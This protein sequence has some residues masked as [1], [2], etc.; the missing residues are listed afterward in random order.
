MDQVGDQYVFGAEVSETDPNPSVWDCAE[1]TQWS[2]Y[3]VGAEIPGSSFEQYLDL[4][5]KGLVIPVEQGM[6]TPGALL[7]H[8]SAE[9]TPGGG[10]PSQA[11][12]ALSLGDG[13]TVEAQSSNVGVI[14]DDNAAGRFEY[15]ALLPNVDYSGA[16]MAAAVAMPAAATALAP[17]AD[18]SGLTI[19]MVI[20]GIKMQESRG[21]YQAENPTSTASGAYQYIDGTWAGYGGYGH[22]SDAPPDVQDARMRADT[23]AAYDRLGDWERVI[24]SHFAGEGGQAGPK[25]EWH[26]VPGNDY[27]QNPSIRDYVDGVLGHVEEAD[28]SA[29]GGVAYAPASAALFAPPGPQQPMIGQVAA[30]VDFVPQVLPGFTIDPGMDISNPEG[31][32]DNDALTNQFEMTTGSNPTV[33]DT[34][35]DGLTDGFEASLGTKATLIDT[36]ADGF[37][38]GFEAM[39]G[40]DPLAAMSLPGSSLPGTGVPVGGLESGPASPLGNP[41]GGTNVP[42]A[43][44]PN[45]PAA[46]VDP[47]DAGADPDVP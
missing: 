42:T 44:D 39:Y 34:D 10:R 36:D 18:A 16:S 6:N 1:F 17:M 43:P 5:A 15:A 38:D 20:H 19:D 37:T 21:D 9:P 30:P 46:G 45:G 35:A 22:A 25:G 47:M 8:F 11:H 26:K 33:G 4:K 14:V 24:A 32:A 23:Q 12:V 40:L 29:F 13:T 28:P 2:A 3:Q 31:D 27:N 7:F 41:M